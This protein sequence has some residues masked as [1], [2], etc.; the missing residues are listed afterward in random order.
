MTNLI[1][2]KIDNIDFM[3]MNT[4]QFRSIWYPGNITYL[5]FLSM[6]PYKTTLLKFYIKGSNLKQVFQICQ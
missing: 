4:G 3:I 5:D 6:I 2:Q 1:A